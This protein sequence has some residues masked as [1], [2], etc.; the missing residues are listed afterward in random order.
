MI[1]S[2]VAV[3]RFAYVR[4]FS[5]MNEF[6]MRRSILA[7]VNGQPWDMHRPLEE[8]CVLQFLHMLDENCELQNKVLQL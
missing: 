1:L 6:L 7:M 2:K 8:D 4:Q 5:D 3:N